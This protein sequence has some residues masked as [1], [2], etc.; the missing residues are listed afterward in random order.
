MNRYKLL[1]FKQQLE[2]QPSDFRILVPWNEMHHGFTRDDLLELVN[3]ALEQRVLAPERTDWARRLQRIHTLLE[4]FFTLPFLKKGGVV[5]QASTEIA[6][7]FD[8]LASY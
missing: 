1:A 7:L 5:R 4:G 3:G 2:D 8:E 6:S